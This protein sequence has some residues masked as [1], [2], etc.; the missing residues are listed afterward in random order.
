MVSIKEVKGATY[1]KPQLDH[2]LDYGLVQKGKEPIVE[3]EISGEKITDLKLLKTCGC[4]VTNTN[5]EG[6]VW[7]SSI[8]Y[9]ATSVKGVFQKT[10]KINYKIAGKEKQELIKIKGNVV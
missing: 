4:S 1:S 2:I 10:V 3:F 5:K 9:T 8:K 7:K 6:T